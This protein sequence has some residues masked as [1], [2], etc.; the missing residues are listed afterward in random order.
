MNM[1]LK[2][3]IEEVGEPLVQHWRAEGRRKY[4]QSTPP[5]L[6]KQ[7]CTNM[8]VR[9]RYSEYVTEKSQQRN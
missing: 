3:I 7:A 9:F 4:H 2:Q 8:H 6:S 1:K 5:D